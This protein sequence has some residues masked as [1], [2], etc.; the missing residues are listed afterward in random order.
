MLGAANSPLSR[1]GNGSSGPSMYEIG[2]NGS[3]GGAVSNALRSTIDRYHAN[4]QSAQEQADQL[5][6]TQA[7]GQTTLGNEKA[8]FDYKRQGIGPDP[9]ASGPHIMKDP[10]TGKFFYANHTPDA[11]TGQMKV[12]WTPVTNSP[13]QDEMKIYENSMI[14]PLNDA[15]AQQNQP[16]AIQQGAS[17]SVPTAGQGGDKRQSAISILQQAGKVVNEDTINR[18]MKQL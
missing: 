9:D 5:A 8:M 18:V 13:P 4:L 3:P 7:A 6:R 12:S 16:N 11:T 2:Y 1:F 14:K 17:A 10:T 15:M